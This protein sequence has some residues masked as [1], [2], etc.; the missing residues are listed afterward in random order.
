MI[1]RILCLLLLAGPATGMCLS[2]QDLKLWYK[3]PAKSWTEALPV[4][5]GRLGGMIYGKVDEELIQLNESSLWSG[6]PVKTKVNRDAPAYLPQIREA[7]LKEADYNKAARL[8]QKMQGLFSE[9]YLP[10]GDLSIRQ[11]FKGSTPTTYY[12]D[13]DIHDPVTTTKFTIDATKFTR[14]I[15]VSAPDQVVVIRLLS[16]KA[17]GLNFTAGVTRQAA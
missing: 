4:G 3:H 11:D 17:G 8:A 15:F 16:G 5:N 6:G 9:S 12:R 10:M 13:L 1:K 14:Q 2:A 7:L